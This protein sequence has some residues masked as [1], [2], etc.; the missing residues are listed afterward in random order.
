MSRHRWCRLGL[1]A[2][3]AA[4]LVAL[5]AT[6]I[7]ILAF[8][9]FDNSTQWLSEL[10]GAQARAPFIFNGGVMIAGLLAASAGLGFG[11]VIAALKGSR[12]AAIMAAIAFVMAGAGLMISSLYPWPDPRHL[13]VNLGL[14]IQLAP[15]L[16]IWG[17][18]KMD[19]VHRL[20][21]FLIA[22]FIAMAV[23]TVI[24]RHLVFRGMVNE[25]NDGLWERAFAV[26]LVGWV[27][28][29]AFALERRLTVHTC[30]D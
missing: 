14:G 6:V 2:G 20:R 13:W 25:T 12:F 3:M 29:A 30:D 17:L 9:G 15:L 27:G 10:G 1:Y 19:G 8:P 24:T 16:L 11:L 26:V 22:S 21:W 4:P 18:W 5:A 7:A 23:L 28:V